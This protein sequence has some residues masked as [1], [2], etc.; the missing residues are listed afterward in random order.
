MGQDNKLQRCLIITK[1]HM[2]MR[3]LHEGPLKGHFAIEI[4]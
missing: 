4:T 3:E 1:A 2:V